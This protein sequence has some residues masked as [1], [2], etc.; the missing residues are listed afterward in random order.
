MERVYYDFW[1][2]RIGDK[3]AT[4]ACLEWFKSE[5]PNTLLI[6]I[7]DNKS[8]RG[9]L[10][11]IPSSVVFPHLVDD[12]CQKRPPDTFQILFG[13]LWIR[14][15]WLAKRNIY[16]SMKVDSTIELQLLNSFKWMTEPYIC[17]HILEDAPYNIGRNINFNNMQKL[18]TLLWKTGYVVVRVGKWPGKSAEHCIDMTQEQLSLMQTA[19]IVKHGTCYVGGDTGITHI[20][21][22]TGVPH[23]FAV[24][25][26]LKTDEVKWKRVAI[27]MN[28]GCEFSTL[29]SVPEKRLS[30]I[31]MHEHQ[32]DVYTTF[33]NICQK[34]NLS[35][36]VGKAE[37]RKTSM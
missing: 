14:L 2:H 18:I 1:R 36:L 3:V 22:A 7:D 35:E 34:M 12:V 31:K 4:S 25:H 16:P 23:I 5:N 9:C 8:F 21:A 15:P 29:P 6:A 37:L 11:T 10:S 20:A 30:I 33:N 27:H 13:C 26:K 28:C 17:I 32:F 19:V 24:Y